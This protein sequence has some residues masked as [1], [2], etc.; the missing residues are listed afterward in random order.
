MRGHS[1]HGTGEDSPCSG[2]IDKSHLRGDTLQMLEGGSPRP[3]IPKML[4]GS[5][6]T[7]LCGKVGIKLGLAGWVH[8]SSFLRAVVS[9]L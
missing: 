8:L 3:Y 7:I 2:L 4:D 6:A 1:V 5:V 9:W